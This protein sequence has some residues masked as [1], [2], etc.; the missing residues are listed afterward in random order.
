MFPG[1]AYRQLLGPGPGPGPGATRARATPRPTRPEDDWIPRHW[2]SPL[3]GVVEGARDFTR[4][5]GEL[6]DL[7]MSLNADQVAVNGSYLDPFAPTPS[8]EG[9]TVLVPRGVRDRYIREAPTAGSRAVAPVV[10]RLSAA[11]Q[12]LLPAHPTKGDQLLRSGGHAVPGLVALANPIAGAAYNGID[13]FGA[14]NESAEAHDKSESEPNLCGAEQITVGENEIDFHSRG[15]E[16][17]E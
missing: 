5:L 10:R 2:G 1:Q 8:G 7:A 11:A 3:G 16:N 15:R 9:V 14:A 6:G 12:H 4:H 17:N 13:A